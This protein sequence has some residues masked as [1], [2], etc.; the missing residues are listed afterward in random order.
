LILLGIKHSGKS[1]LGKL[2]A[3]RLRVLFFDTDAVI[4]RQ[5]GK[6]P[7]EL[8]LTE[9]EAAFMRAEADACGYLDALLKERNQAAVIATGGG[10]CNNPQAVTLL[11]GMGMLIYLNVSEKTA[12]NRIVGRIQPIPEGGLAGIPAYIARENPQTI[13]DVRQIFHRFYEERTARY[14]V[15]A[16][17]TFSP[18]D[19][20]PE[21]N[22]RLLA[23]LCHPD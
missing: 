11:Q 23:T 12:A 17:K 5:T 16:D 13:D 6:S 21:E 19:M 20:P 18:Q 9:G 14:A 10:V 4:T 3:S 8:Y 22:A 2:L 7:R 1:T 15:L